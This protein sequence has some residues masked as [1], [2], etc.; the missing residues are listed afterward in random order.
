MLD[1]FMNIASTPSRKNSAWLLAAALGVPL[2]VAVIVLSIVLMQS[3]Q[4]SY[5]APAAAAAAPPPASTPPTAGTKGSEPM[6]GDGAD[7][8]WYYGGAN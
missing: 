4:A 1:S 5:S 7:K 8:S 2:A 6:P 3:S